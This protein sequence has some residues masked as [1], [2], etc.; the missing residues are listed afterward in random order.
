MSFDFME[1]LA[2]EGLLNRDAWAALRDTAKDMLRR[3]GRQIALWNRAWLVLK[4]LTP[5]QLQRLGKL[6]C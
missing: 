3:S 1:G 2:Q 5:P 6:L 4:C